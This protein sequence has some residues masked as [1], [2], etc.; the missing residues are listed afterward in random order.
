[1]P[2]STGSCTNPTSPPP[3]WTR[4]A[5]ALRVEVK[6]MWRVMGTSYKSQIIIKAPIL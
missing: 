2:C 6:K 1:M 3:D 4:N 5:V